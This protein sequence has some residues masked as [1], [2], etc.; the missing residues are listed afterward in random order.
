MLP[1]ASLPFP[2][3]N[4]ILIQ[5]GPLAV[6]WYGIGYIVGILFA[7]WY[8]KRLVTN[9]R[10]WPDGVL[11]MKPIDLDDFTTRRVK[12]HGLFGLLLMSPAFQVH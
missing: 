12:L 9:T 2:N 11:P 10:L 4:P 3:I 7:W 6:H 1:L 8:A 5:I